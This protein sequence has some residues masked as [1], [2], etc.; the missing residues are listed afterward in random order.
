MRVTPR[1]SANERT[2]L[3]PAARAVIARM[4]P[5]MHRRV[6]MAAAARDMSMGAYVIECLTAAL[7]AGATGGHK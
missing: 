3:R 2:T 6:R 7:A 4:P 5:D 1:N